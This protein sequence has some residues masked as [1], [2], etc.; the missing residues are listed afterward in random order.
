M[1]GGGKTVESISSSS[2]KRLLLLND[3]FLGDHG[4]DLPNGSIS[5]AYFTNHDE[6]EASKDNYHHGKMNTFRPRPR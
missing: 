4:M 6:E 3:L 2:S 1:N 5:Q